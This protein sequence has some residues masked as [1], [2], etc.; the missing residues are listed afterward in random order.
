[1]R[2]ASRLWHC[3]G[4][5]PQRGVWALA[6]CP[7]RGRGHLDLRPRGDSSALSHVPAVLCRLPRPRAV[8]QSVTCY[9]LRTVSHDNPSSSSADR[10]TR[11]SCLAAFCLPLSPGLSPP[12][13]DL[14][15]SRERAL[16]QPP[17]PPLALRLLFS[18]PYKCTSLPFRINRTTARQGGYRE[19]PELPHL[20]GH[21]LLHV[22][23]ASMKGSWLHSVCVYTL[24]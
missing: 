16:L 20:K 8:G 21:R 4:V 7:G 14:P 9:R 13:P 23:P 3:W 12:S 22:L 5:G 1:M 17:S 15:G 19:T 11:P 6:A 2:A 18:F 24:K 10:P